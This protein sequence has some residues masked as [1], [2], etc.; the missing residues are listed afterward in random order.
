M[1]EAEVTTFLAHLAVNR[2]VSA[3]T[4]SQ[5]LAVILFLYR[6]VLGVKLP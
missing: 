5:A 2:N 6:E 1:G 4:Q 3:R